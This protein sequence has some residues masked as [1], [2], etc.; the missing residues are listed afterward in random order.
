MKRNYA[1]LGNMF[2]NYLC[3]A[4]KAIVTFFIF[5][6]LKPSY[7]LCHRYTILNISKLE[8]SVYSGFKYD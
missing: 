2:G 5:G 7:A 8:I 6:V 1:T 3:K 4:F